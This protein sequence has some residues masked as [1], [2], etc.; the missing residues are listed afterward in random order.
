LPTAAFGPSLQRHVHKGVAD[1]GN[2]KQGSKTQVKTVCGRAK[3]PLETTTSGP[4]YL[5]KE[6]RHEGRGA[7]HG[8]CGYR[9][10]TLWG[11]MLTIKSHD[12]EISITRCVEKI[13]RTLVPNSLEFPYIG[14]LPSTITLRDLYSCTTPLITHSES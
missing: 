4:K 13:V 6:A 3:Q 10:L 5:I 12:V 14:V 8:E 9:G 11:W 2:P 7:L 1:R